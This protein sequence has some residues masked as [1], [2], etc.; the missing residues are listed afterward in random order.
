MVDVLARTATVDGVQTD[1]STVSGF[2]VTR[3]C[4][5]IAAAATA[6]VHFA[7]AGEH[8]AEYWLFGVF[9]LVVA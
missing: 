3:Y 6:V 8:F 7:V 5:A 4:L 1:Q 9:M 2:K